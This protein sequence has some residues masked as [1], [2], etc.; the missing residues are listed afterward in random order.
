MKL[1]DTMHALLGPIAALPDAWAAE[2]AKRQ[3]RA[4]HDP[5][6]EAMASCAGE[7][8]GAIAE[9]AKATER[10]SARA[11]AALPRNNTTEQ[12]VRRWCRDGLVPGAVQTARGWEIP[13]DAVVK[14]A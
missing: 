9:A 13:R 12:T 4:P 10:I 3:A 5:I 7:L 8:R 14:R 2:I 1:D 6:A 11:F